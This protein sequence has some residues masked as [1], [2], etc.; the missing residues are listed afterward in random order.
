MSKKKIIFF[1]N[2]MKNMALSVAKIINAEL[3]EIQWKAFDD[4]WPNLFIKD[5]EAIKNRDVVFIANLEKSENLFAQFAIIYSLPT[6]FVRSLRVIIPFYPVGTMERVTVYGEIATAVTLA[7]MISATS[8]TQ[9][10][11]VIFSIFDIHSLH[12]QF[13]FEKKILPEIV[14]ATELLC[15]RLEKER[16][17]E[18]EVVIAFPDDG[19]HKRF[20]NMFPKYS[21]HIICNKVRMPDGSKIVTIKEGN[22][23]GKHVVIVDDLIQTGGTLIECRNLLMKAGAKKV[24]AWAT[25]GV[26]AKDSYLKFTPDLFDH[27]W[28][29][30]SCAQTVE[31][32]SKQK[33]FEVLSLAPL[34]AKLF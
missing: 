34:I 15:K 24:S 7:Q 23:E 5:A 6:H 8:M 14:T 29:T 2:S 4:G 12:V 17:Q 19:A 28:I 3:E 27:V 33:N 1:H 11:P 16:G 10:G 21:G 31:K 9:T 26:F 20:K 13:Y 30:D 22:P 18:D 32:V 25:H